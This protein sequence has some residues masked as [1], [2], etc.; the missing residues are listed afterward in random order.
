MIIEQ[1]LPK[2]IINIILEY[3]G[4]IKYRKGKYINIIDKKDPRYNI[5][6]LVISN[7]NKMIEKITFKYSCLFFYYDFIIDK[8]A[9]LFFDINKCEISCYNKRSLWE[10]NFFED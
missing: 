1:Y 9:G 10:N 3:D 5:I 2:E 7:K 4:R 6:E 8:T